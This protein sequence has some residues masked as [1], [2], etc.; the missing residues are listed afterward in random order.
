MKL[1]REAR[2]TIR[3]SGA[4]IAGYTRHHFPDGAWHGDKCGCSDD[5]CIGHHHDERDDCGCLG[6]LLEDYLSQNVTASA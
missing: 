4:T 6:V 2:E 1:S 3:L 5:R